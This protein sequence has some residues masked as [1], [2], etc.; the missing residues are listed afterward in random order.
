MTSRA[1]RVV[2]SGISASLISQ[3][4][5]SKHRSGVRSRDD[6]SGSPRCRR[7]VEAD[8][9]SLFFSEASIKRISGRPLADNYFAIYSLAGSYRPANRYAIVYAVMPKKGDRFLREETGRALPARLQS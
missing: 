4:R 5:E 9:V 2:K 7:F 6:P 3:S 1:C 8:S